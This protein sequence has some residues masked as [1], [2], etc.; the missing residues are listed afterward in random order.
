VTASDDVHKEVEGRRNGLSG[1]DEV[2]QKPQ[3]SGDHQTSR[4]HDEIVKPILLA[5]EMLHEPT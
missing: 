1:H 5:T 4:C 3:N 2:L